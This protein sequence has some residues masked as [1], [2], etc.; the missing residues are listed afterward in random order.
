[1]FLTHHASLS[2]SLY[3]YIPLFRVPSIHTVIQSI[4]NVVSAFGPDG[5]INTDAGEIPFWA[6]IGAF[7]LFINGICGVILG[8]MAC[9]HDFSHPYLTL[10]M[11]VI[12]QTAWIPYMTDMSNLGMMADND[13]S[14]Q[15]L[16][17]AGHNPTQ[18]DVRFVSAMA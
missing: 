12:I 16:I 4:R 13:P 17:P 10:G 11:I 2:L 1:M 6:M 3:I 9:V 15:G 7:C 14:M 8:Y 18:G 5:A